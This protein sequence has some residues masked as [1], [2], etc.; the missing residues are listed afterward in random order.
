MRGK[1][2]I[3]RCHIQTNVSTLVHGFPHLGQQKWLSFPDPFEELPVLP[4]PVAGG[5][6]GVFVPALHSQKV[7]EIDLL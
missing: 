7:V 1:I 6:V 3:K 4:F 2:T 5:S